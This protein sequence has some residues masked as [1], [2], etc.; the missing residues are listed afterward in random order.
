M[1][2]LDRDISPKFDI[3][4]LGCVLS[5]F[6]VYVV[7]NWD[8]VIAYR[9]ERKSET[10]KINN[11]KDIGCFHDT[12]SVLKSVSRRHSR[13]LPNEVRKLDFVTV[14]IIEKM[15]RPMLTPLN[16][17]QD[18]THFLRVS[19][20][21]L[22][23]SRKVVDQFMMGQ[24]NDLLESEEAEV[25]V[26]PGTSTTIS[27]MGLDRRLSYRDAPRY[28]LPN[29]QLDEPSLHEGPE[30]G[31]RQSPPTTPDFDHGVR[32]DSVELSPT[33]ATSQNTSPGPWTP[34][35]TFGSSNHFRYGSDDSVKAKRAFSSPPGHVFP[36]NNPSS[37][38]FVRTRYL[39]NTQHLPPSQPKPD[40]T[41]SRHV[42]NRPQ[43]IRIEREPPRQNKAGDKKD[44]LPYVTFEEAKNRRATK[45]KL[46][47]EEIVEELGK[48]DVVSGVHAF[49]VLLLTSYLT[50]LSLGR[51]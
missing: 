23:E 29:Q 16:L 36:E 13:L 7:H 3:W 15:I 33:N 30:T 42:V 31:F 46:G 49:D 35:N 26:P 19:Q 4:S 2:R 20:D 43:S 51:C 22:A 21:L 41:P 14:P 50:D 6:A 28:S 9:D 18:A 8:G 37:P 27:F 39:E 5:E 10:S 12:R 45:R 44:D 1:D 38:Q 40:L 32:P 11:H 24:E 25:A 17:R 47:C 34:Q 48:R